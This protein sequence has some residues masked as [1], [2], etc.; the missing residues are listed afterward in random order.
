MFFVNNTLLIQAGR[1]KINIVFIVFFF[2]NYCKKSKLY[3]R[4]QTL[5]FKKVYLV[6]FFTCL[7]TIIIKIQLLD[8]SFKIK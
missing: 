6:C 3:K 5:E 7:L 4:Q 1:G 2:H 8:I